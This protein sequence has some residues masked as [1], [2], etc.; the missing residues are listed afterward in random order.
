MRKD[1]KFGLIVGALICG[2]FLAVYM[3]GLNNDS[4][5]QDNSARAVGGS[6]QS[7]SEKE[8]SKTPGSSVMPLR[9][10]ERGYLPEG[11]EDLI[12][13]LER[14]ARQ[15]RQQTAAEPDTQNASER[16][17]ADTPT[18]PRQPSEPKV[19]KYTVVSG[20]TLS[21]ISKKFY[22]T[23]SQWQKILE[24]NRQTLKNPAGLK[25]GM[26]LVIPE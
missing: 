23:T 19:R 5:V 4:P 20:D 10:D 13:K 22:G 14:Q 18:S 12:D 8:A 9:S 11:E 17:Q 24:A 25:P 7:G 3:I 26:E 15:R 1:F 16:T 21:G 6:D 2:V